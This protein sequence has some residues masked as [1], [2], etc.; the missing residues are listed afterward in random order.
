MSIV[1]LDYEQWISYLYDVFLT[2]FFFRKLYCAE[3]GN[4]RLLWAVLPLLF[5]YP[6]MISPV[7]VNT[8]PLRYLYRWGLIFLALLC[9][10]VG[11]WQRCAYFASLCGLGF[12]VVQNFLITSRVLTKF[13]ALNLAS[14]LLLIVLMQY[15]MP[16][17]VFYL[18]SSTVAWDQLEKIHIH[19]AVMVLLLTP[20]CLY[21]KENYFALNKQTEAPSL[22]EC[23]YPIIISM[24]TLVIVAYFDRFFILRREKERQALIDLSRQYQFR[25]LQDQL[26]AHQ[27]IRHLHH[28]MKNH[29]LTLSALGNEQQQNYIRT[30]LTQMDGFGHLVETNNSTANVLL[31]Q[32]VRLAAEKKIRVKIDL[33]LS[34]VAYIDPIDVCSLFGNALDNAIEAAEQVEDE[35]KR[36]VSVCGGV[37]ANMYVVRITNSCTGRLLYR[38]NGLLRTTKSNAAQHGIGLENMQHTLRRYQGVLTYC[39]EGDTFVLKFMLPQELSSQKV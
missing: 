9:Y 2:L 11:G 27:E 1:L 12:L 38:P 5:Y 15:L 16:L 31:G 3:K 35:E 19:Q 28:D 22:Q 37:Y 7:P 39:L 17:V 34:P 20:T 18:V 26:A 13:Y 10:G 33:D 6:L 21:V 23:A 36:F 25:N 32:K 8:M 4:L 14:N 29:L 30:L 24:L